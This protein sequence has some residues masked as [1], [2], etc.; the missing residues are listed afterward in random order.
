MINFKSKSIICDA[1]HIEKIENCETN[2]TN[3][4]I[5]VKN[6]VDPKISQV[7]EFYMSEK[8]YLQL[9]SK[10]QS[11]H[12]VDLTRKLLYEKYHMQLYSKSITDVK[13]LKR[14]V[15]KRASRKGECQLVNYIWFKNK[16]VTT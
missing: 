7:I 6:I 3:R 12:N 14:I 13:F 15:H 11:S 9:Y 4:N 2:Y 8:C 5:F 10:R 1:Y 16:N